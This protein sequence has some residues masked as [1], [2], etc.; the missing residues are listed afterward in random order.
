M[1]ELANPDVAVLLARGAGRLA[2]VAITLDRHPAPADPDPWLGLLLI[3]AGEQRKGYGREM[4]GLVEER[5]R[6]RGRAALRRAAPDNNP[7]ALAF[8]QALR[9]E[10]IA[11]R[12]DRRQ[13]RPCAALRQPL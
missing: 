10:V 12:T 5:F 6:A 3:D 2:G 9:Y 7:R 1:Q 11:H 13:G 4:A 8:W